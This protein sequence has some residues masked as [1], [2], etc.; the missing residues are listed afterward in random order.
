MTSLEVHAAGGL[1]LVQDLG[2]PGQAALGVP[3]GGAADPR[4]LALA[5]RAVGNPMEAAGLE[6]LLGGLQLEFDHSVV[7]CITG[8]PLAVTVDGKPVAF[9]APVVVAPGRR[10]VLGTPT[11][12]LRT[13]VAIRG[14]LRVPHVL[15]S[16]ASS[17]TAGIGPAALTAHDTLE[18]G[19]ADHSIQTGVGSELVAAVG[20]PTSDIVLHAT[21]GPRDD[22]FTQQAVKRL[23]SARW[24][25]TPDADRVGVRLEGPVLDR[26]VT[27]ELPSEGVVPG[28][29]Q[30][31]ASG[32]PIV[33]GPDHPTTGGYP[34]IA[35]VREEDLGA[36]YQAKPGTGLRFS[37]QPPR[38]C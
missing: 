38:W 10:L 6:V 13:Y 15:G 34:V 26:A 22:W 27:H 30:V 12:S 7:V 23:S 29:V 21:L 4:S 20:D 1:T 31:P 35:V 18:I 17:P 14:G 24:L 8:A 32:Q 5:N 19:E 3:R 9:G 33:F 36:L 25:T 28:A 37:I 2:R 16:A 11:A